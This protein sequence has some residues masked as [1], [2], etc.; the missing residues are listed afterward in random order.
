MWVFCR[1]KHFFGQASC[2]FVISRII[3]ERFFIIFQKKVG[4]VRKFSL[5][6]SSRFENTKR[7]FLQKPALFNAHPFLFKKK[8]YSLKYR[9]CLIWKGFDLRIN[10]LTLI[11]YII[12]IIINNYFS[13]KI[14][15]YGSMSWS[16]KSVKFCIGVAESK[17][18]NSSFSIYYSS[19]LVLHDA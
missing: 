16:T 6:Y 3:L 12:L 13:G 1:L 4:I 15:L 11:K 18:W 7:T 2:S 9:T 17:Y 19:I 5:F 10:V 8:F 14:R